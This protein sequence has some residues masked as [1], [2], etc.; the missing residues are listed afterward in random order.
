MVFLLVVGIWLPYGN[1]RIPPGR[2]GDRENEVP[3]LRIFWKNGVFGVFGSVQL[4]YGVLVRKI[5]G[6]DIDFR[7]FHVLEGFWNPWDTPGEE[8]DMENRLFSMSS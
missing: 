4:L 2:Q 5:Y 6:L 8:G 3:G 7:D 1:P